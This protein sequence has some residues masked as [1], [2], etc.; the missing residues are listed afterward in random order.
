MKPGIASP[1]GHNY[2]VTMWRFLLPALLLFASE[3]RAD[4]NEVHIM[5]LDG[6]TIS[7]VVENGF[8]VTQGDIIL[9]RADEVETY[10]AASQRRDFT[11]LARLRPLSIAST[12]TKLWPNSTAYYVIDSDIPVMQNILDAIAYWNDRQPFKLIPRTD[13][14]N[15]IHFRKITTDAACNSSVG[16]IGGEQF[17]GV[18]AGCSTGAAIHEIGHSWGLLHEQERYD[19]GAF[20]TVLYENIDK[21]YVNNFNQITSSKD[22]SY[23]DYDS[24][25]HYGPTGFATNF[26]DTLATVPAG[27]PIGQRAKL[28][29][30]DLDG[31]LRL[32]GVTPRE[33]TITTTPEGLPLTVDGQ[34]VISPQSFSWAPN[35]THT[36]SAPEGQGVSPRYVFARWTDRGGLSHTIVAS[37]DTTVYC[38]QYSVRQPV[39]A[40]VAS[41][42]GTVSVFPTPVDGYLPD[43]YPFL[44]SAKPANGSSF[45]RWSGSTSLSSAGLS[46]SDA[47]ARVGVKGGPSNYQA[48]FTTA[49]VTTVDAQPAGA[50]V[51]VD[52]V[53]YYAPVNFAWAPG[54]MHTLN[55]TPS[56]LTGTNTT[57]YQFLNWE[58]G[59]TGLRTVTAGGATVT[60]RANFNKQYLVSA[61]TIGNGSVALSPS[62]PDGFYDAG[63][64]VTVTANAGS[65]QVLRYWLGDLGGASPT[66]A[67]IADQTRFAVANFGTKLPWLI[68]NAATLNVN[69]IPQTSGQIVA[70]G[71]LVSAFGEGI[72]PA[73][74]QFP[75][76]GNDGKLPTSVA[77][78]SVLFDQT[79]APITYAGPNQINVVVPFNLA[80]KTQTTVT[81]KNAAGSAAV[82]ILVA[83]TSPGL[84]TYNGSGSGPVAALNQDGS[85]NSRENPAAA[86]SVVI[87]YGTGAGTWQKTFPDG[88]ILG[89]D[90]ASPSEPVYVRF[91][92]LDSQVYYAGTAPYLV[93]GALQINA[94]VPPETIGGQVP[95]QFIVGRYTSAPGTT[96]WVK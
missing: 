76:P 5:E 18:T 54:S 15:Y 60:Y 25:M 3:T 44:V 89:A 33:T 38:A 55:V 84:F 62:S 85:L 57:R 67:L 65:G 21:R 53:S 1:E 10:R 45:I 40:G 96:I 71:E 30:G 82:G 4:S 35:S 70:P 46:V 86:G 92:R 39:Q 49:P 52:G 29:A 66:A 78:V 14:P 27:I 50:A 37:P 28:S 90:L 12:G 87:L 6:R 63:T 94:V 7:Y 42:A 56:Q 59:S 72:G 23:Y 91:G 73:G 79:A 43:R 88:Q 22:L 48:N 8:A 24:I 34:P 19:R 75:A 74:Q 80:G 69:S 17:V 2:N 36:I 61:A 58:D 41:G 32:Y 64:N 11:A 83:D 13:Q 68:L 81:V 26:E 51:L 47:A 31:V 95:L 77:G 93:N 9:G 16:M 20:I